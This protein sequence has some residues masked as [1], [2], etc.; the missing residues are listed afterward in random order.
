MA[1]ASISWTTPRPQRSTS[2]PVTNTPLANPRG[3][4]L[5][6]QKSPILVPLLPTVA[7]ILLPA[8]NMP[9]Y[10]PTSP[11]RTVAPSA[12]SP[13]PFA[14]PQVLRQKG[15]IYQASVSGLS[16]LKNVSKV[17]MKRVSSTAHLSVKT[18]TVPGSPAG[19][20]NAVAVH[21]GCEHVSV[22]VN[23]VKELNPSGLSMWPPL[24]SCWNWP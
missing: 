13:I 3:T 1:A 14:A 11:S 6:A 21:P 2:E 23:A 20:V 9:S 10:W 17:E 16:P 24:S 5:L 18:P 8:T 15:L 19:G 22:R 7:H 4:P 12:P